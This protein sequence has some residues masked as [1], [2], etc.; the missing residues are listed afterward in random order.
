MQ[1]RA[2]LWQNGRLSTSASTQALAS[3]VQDPQALTWLDIQIEDHPEQ[4]ADVLSSVFKLSH[5]TIQTVEEERERAKL[6]EGDGYYHLVV[7]G[8]GY[9][10]KTNEASTP[11]L[12]IVFGKNFLITIHRVPLAWLNRLYKDM[13]GSESEENMMSRGMPFLLYSLIDS[14]VDSYF[15]VLDDVDEQID[16]LES[17]AV[18]VAN[19]A[20]Q[21]QI[22]QVKRALAQMRRVISPQVEVGNSLIT[23]TG[24]LIP[25]KYEPYFSDV[26]DHLVRSFEILDSYRDLTSTLLDVYLT[27]V[28]NRMNEI[29]KQLTIVA[30]IFMPITFITGIFGQNFGFEPQVAWDKGF[31]FWIILGFMAFITIAQIW[32]FKYKQWL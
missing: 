7:H 8:L 30:T 9:D 15:P 25:Q 6:V 20:V 1:E 13:H 28:N 5:L 4:V 29:M 26:H 22:F 12:D 14:L 21:G 32:Y 3:S 27:T 18:N 2:L 23:R 19:N 11:K 24:D 10:V 16:D 17:A 31:D